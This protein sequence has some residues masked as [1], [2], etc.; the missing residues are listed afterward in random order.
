MDTFGVRNGAVL[1]CV[2]GDDHEYPLATQRALTR[3]GARRAFAR[4]ADRLATAEREPLVTALTE[5][6]E[7]VEVVLK[8]VERRRVVTRQHRPVPPGA[9]GPD[10]GVREPRRPIPPSGSAGVALDLP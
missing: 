7:V 5:E 4:L 2:D 10:A 9:N 3:R 1:V 8:L 6:G